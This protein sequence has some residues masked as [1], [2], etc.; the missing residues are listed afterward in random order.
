MRWC[1]QCGGEAGLLGVLGVLK[2][3]LC[4]NCG[5]QFSTRVKPRKRKEPSAPKKRGR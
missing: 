5:M 2:H 4:R 1:S 3:W